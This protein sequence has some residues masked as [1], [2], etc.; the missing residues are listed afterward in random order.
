ML[1][2]PYSTPTSRLTRS[3][4]VLRIYHASK[5]HTSSTAESTTKNVLPC[6][7]PLLVELLAWVQ[8]R[9]GV[10]AVAA[11]TVLQMVILATTVEVHPAT[12]GS[13]LRQHELTTRDLLHTTPLR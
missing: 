12:K 6:P 2:M 10:L 13:P 9:P 8:T 11:T 7:L 5:S 3:P 4:P 1:G